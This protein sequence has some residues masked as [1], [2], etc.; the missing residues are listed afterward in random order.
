MSYYEYKTYPTA[1]CLM[2]ER[3]Y[4]LKELE[5]IVA[6][7]HKMN[8]VAVKSMKEIRNEQSN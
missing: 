3:W 4:T 2:E 7:I 8:A 1:G 5:E 6:A